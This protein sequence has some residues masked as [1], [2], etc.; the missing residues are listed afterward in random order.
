MD[1]RSTFGIVAA[2]VVVVGLFGCATSQQEEKIVYLKRPDLLKKYKFIP[3]QKAWKDKNVDLRKY[4]K[5]IV[6]PVVT[7]QRLSKDELE[8]LNLDELLGTQKEKLLKFAEYTRK[9]FEKAVREEPGLQLATKPGPNT[10]I[11]KLVLVK[12]VPGKPL[13]GIIRNVPLPIGQAGFIISPAAKV[14]GAT[15]SS[16]KASVAIE[17]EFLD[18]QSRKVV[19]MFADKETEKTAI[20]NFN[21]MSPYATPEAIVDEWAKLLLKCLKRQPGQVIEK[22]SKY[23]LIEY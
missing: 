11:L 16:M 6:E 8:K 1:K 17:G 3:F 20:L 21:L 12:V 10:L 19:A 5:I 22:P 23:K 14:T 18:S 9:A 4:D 2:L 13:F 7:S 15:I